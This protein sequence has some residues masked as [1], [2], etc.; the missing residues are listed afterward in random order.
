MT[1]FGIDLW[2]II[3]CVVLIILVVKRAN[4][5]AIFAKQKYAKKDYEGALKIFKVANVI[6]NLNIKNK[7]LYG[8]ALL[9]CGHVDEAQ[10]QFRNTLP[11]TKADSADRYQLKNLI[12]LTYWKQGNLPDAIEELEEVIEKGYKN[13]QIYQNLG[14]LYNLS[15]NHEKA[16]KFN[17]EAYEY[18]KDDNIICDNLADIYAICGEYEKS[19]QIYEELHSREPE[20]RFPEAYYGYGKVL[21]KLGEKEKGIEMIEKS[22]TKPFS[23]LSIRPKEEIEKLLSDVKNERL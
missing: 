4:I 3:T 19:K 6:G 12:A 18:N 1:L 11:L 8:Y 14:I 23:Y 9:R 7:E 13:T 21:I 17:E 16:K 10:V 20:P 2:R 15:D 22:L 5:V